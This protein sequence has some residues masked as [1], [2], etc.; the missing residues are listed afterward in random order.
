MLGLVAR[1]LRGAPVALRLRAGESITCA[2]GSPVASV[3]IHDR[4]TLVRL[5]IDADLAFGEAYTRGRVHVEGDELAFFSAVARQ[6]A[7]RG[8]MS[9]W[10]ARI[11]P[12]GIARSRRQARHHY[13]LGNDFYRLWLDPE[14]VYTCAYYAR[15]DLSLEEAQV[16]KLDYVARK[17]DLHAGEQ[18]FEAGG[19]WGALALH[20][21]RRYG[22]RVRSWN[23]SHEQVEWARQRARREGLATLVEFVED[24][25]RAMTGTCDA[26]VSVGMVEHVGLPKLARLGAVIDGTLDRARGRGLLH[27]IGRASPAPMGHWITR[28]IFPGSYLPVLSDVTSRVLEPHALCVLDV[29]N[30][31]PHYARTLDAWR[32]RF[33]Q[34]VDAVRSAF[35]DEFARMW[36]LYLSEA[37]A[38]FLGGSLQLFQ[39]T[40]ARPGHTSGS[41]TRAP[42]YR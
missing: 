41:W 11:A 17:L 2:E 6:L 7:E 10:H 26:F 21:A 13:D 25:Y 4:A 20:L 16:E 22:V 33:G 14:M 29:E 32:V 36:H 23:V 27:F 1:A 42:L 38:G 8:A 5:V 24:D 37:E 12:K 30:L 18:V 39:V 31:R 3:V 34:H 35:G 15:P 40:F 9:T 28:R 19:G